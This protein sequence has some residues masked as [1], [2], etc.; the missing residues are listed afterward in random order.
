MLD[1]LIKFLQYVV[2][3]VNDVGITLEIDKMVL[4]YTTGSTVYNI[5]CLVLFVGHFTPG[6]CLLSV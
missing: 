4:A 5:A 6:F 2:S 3:Q 1:L